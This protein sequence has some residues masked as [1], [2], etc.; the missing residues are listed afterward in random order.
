MV[1][2]PANDAWDPYTLPELDTDN[3][4]AIFSYY[5]ESYALLG[6]IVDKTFTVK[7]TCVYAELGS[8]GSELNFER[9]E[10][11]LDSAVL[12]FEGVPGINNGAN[13]AK[14]TGTAVPRADEIVILRTGVLEYCV[15]IKAYS[16]AVAGDEPLQWDNL[17]GEDRAI[18]FK[19]F[20]LA[21]IDSAPEVF[22]TN[23]SNRCGSGPFCLQA[24]SEACFLD[25]TTGVL[26]VEWSR[27]TSTEVESY[28]DAFEWFQVCAASFQCQRINT[29][30]EFQYVRVPDVAK[31]DT[32]F[33]FGGNAVNGAPIEFECA[34]EL[35]AYQLYQFARTAAQDPLCP[36]AVGGPYERA[37]TA[38]RQ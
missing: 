30:G 32:I 27:G 9:P 14:F 29:G 28:S 22:L 31:I 16:A 19:N 15:S 36:M 37:I 2:C 25:P 13:G 33:K 11:W 8:D 7:D 17:P 34:S 3:D 5:Q 1:E 6:Q 4:V 23:Q 21:I 20:L 12:H 38:W 26:H 18:E 35:A 10:E 24:G